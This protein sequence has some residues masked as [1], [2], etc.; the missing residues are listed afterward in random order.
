MPKFV[1][2]PSVSVQI[3]DTDEDSFFN[4]FNN[5]QLHELK[6]LIELKILANKKIAESLE[7][8]AKDIAEKS[9]IIHKMI[10]DMDAKLAEKKRLA[11]EIVVEKSFF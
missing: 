5:T 7:K 9:V 10:A 11:E 2:L 6:S 4:S 8:E 1:D 3:D